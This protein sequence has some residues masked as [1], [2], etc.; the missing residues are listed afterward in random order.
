VNNASNSIGAKNS[1]NTSN[2]V[3]DKGKSIGDSNNMA[4][5]RRNTCNGMDTSNIMENGKTMHGR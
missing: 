2:R 1:R 4:K 5:N 3:R